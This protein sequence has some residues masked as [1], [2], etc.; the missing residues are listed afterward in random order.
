MPKA[1]L[2]L[3][4][5][6]L[7][8]LHAISSNATTT[9]MTARKLAVC[10]GTVLLS[11]PEEDMLPV[12]V[13]VEVMKVRCIYQPATAFQAQPRFAV[14]RFQAASSVQQTLLGE[15][16]ARAA[17]QLQL[18]SRSHGGEWERPLDLVAATG[19]ETNGFL[20]AGDRAG[21]APH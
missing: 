3:L 16:L 10:L 8:L 5:D 7:S 21:A 18:L 9:R 11:P 6:L 1:N 13:L 2:L 20:C 19:A 17:P 15:L 12:D 4:K 14:Q